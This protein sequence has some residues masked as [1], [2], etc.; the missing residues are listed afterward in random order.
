MGARLALSIIAPGLMLLLPLASLAA[1]GPRASWQAEW[2][3]T[4]RA[5]EK[6]GEVAFYTLGDY[7]YLK[8]FE[9]RYPRIRVLVV[10]GRGNELLSRIMTERR[11]GK[12][13]VDVAR[14][15]NTSPYE[16]YRAKVLQPIRSAFILPEVLDESLWW[17]GR[18]HYADPEAKYIFVPVGNASINLVGYNT[19][20]V[21]PRGLK[22]Y[23]DLLQPQWKGKIVVMDPRAGGYG[24]SGAR[25]V[26]YNPQLGPSFLSRLLSE[27]EVTLSR[28]YRQ[29]IDWLAQR[30]FSLYL[31]G[32]GGDLLEARAKGLPVQVM[33]TAPWRE[34]SAL[35]PSA[36]TFVLPDRPAHPHA[37]K[38]LVNWLLSRPGQMAIQSEAETNDSLRIDIPK[39][40]VAPVVRRRAGAKY[41]VTWNPEWMDM[42]PIRR[43]VEQLL[44][45][46]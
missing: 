5:A 3:E 28:D 14:I 40:E 13:L 24:R 42:E 7:G 10:P 18:H 9:K 21:D 15:G 35:E 45:K 6:E 22:S 31:F 37:A 23:W 38:V 8:E 16:L 25:F 30:R 11:A 27:M 2:E 44:G 41:V 33:D 17:Q 34:G 39:E 19:D 32:N 36:F 46:R 4:V 26:Y 29:A 43:L 20:L 1:E 12:Y